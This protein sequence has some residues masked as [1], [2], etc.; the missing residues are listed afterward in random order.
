MITIVSLFSK[1]FSS[2]F[3]SLVMHFIFVALEIKPLETK[4][5]VH[6]RPVLSPSHIP[7]PNY[8]E[9]GMF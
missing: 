3:Y 6:A 5:A 2:F 9:K 1:D 8:F 4:L 7:S